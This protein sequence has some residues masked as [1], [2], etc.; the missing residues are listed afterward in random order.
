VKYYPKNFYLL[1]KRKAMT[2]LPRGYVLTSLKIIIFPENLKAF[3]LKAAN[4]L[5]VLS[6][7]SGD[8]STILKNASLPVVLSEIPGFHTASSA[9]QSLY[10]LNVIFGM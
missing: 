7:I 2:N 8:F 3:Y 6:R 5:T 4:S 9:G 1:R 10:S